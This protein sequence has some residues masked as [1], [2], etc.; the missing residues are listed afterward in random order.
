MLD[1]P[2]ARTNNPKILEMEINK[3][4]S[5]DIYN[6]H[7]LLWSVIHTAYSDV[8]ISILPNVIC[9]VIVRFFN[10]WHAFP[11]LSIDV[12]G[13]KSI[14]TYIIMLCRNRIE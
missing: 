2:G 4:S 7:S 8:M 5:V 3:R 10:G 11:Y 1:S 9:S 14:R 12:L 6:I 13:K